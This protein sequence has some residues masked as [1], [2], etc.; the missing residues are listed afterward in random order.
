MPSLMAWA[1]GTTECDSPKREAPRETG[2]ALHSTLCPH[3]D[4]NETCLQALEEPGV[5][6]PSQEADRRL[7]YCSVQGLEERAN[8]EGTEMCF[9][10]TLSMSCGW[11]CIWKR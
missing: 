6:D 11:L 2:H 7:L 3:T 1:Q 4:E 5:D 9:A 10:G 8:V